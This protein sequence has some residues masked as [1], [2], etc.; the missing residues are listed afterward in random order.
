MTFIDKSIITSTLATKNVEIYV[1][2]ID[3]FWISF[4]LGTGIHS[5]NAYGRGME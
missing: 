1:I 3:E 4:V 2:T 5:Q